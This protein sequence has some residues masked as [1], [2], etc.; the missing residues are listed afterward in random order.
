MA[1]KRRTSSARISLST[2]AGADIRAAAR[3]GG[4]INPTKPTKQV[5]NAHFIF[6]S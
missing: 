5:M 4:S 6:T 2:L 1:R 3:V